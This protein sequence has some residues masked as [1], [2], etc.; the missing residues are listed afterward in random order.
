MIKIDRMNENDLDIFR[1]KKVIVD[2]TN[3]D[4]F[5]QIAK[6]FKIF[7]VDIAAYYVQN[8]ISLMHHIIVKSFGGFPKIIQK[9]ELAFYLKNT[10]NIIYLGEN[11]DI[12]ETLGRNLNLDSYDLVLSEFSVGQII[13]SFQYVLL[14]HSFANAIEI[15]MKYFYWDLMFDKEKSPVWNEFVNKNLEE[16]VVICSPQKTADVS[17][18]TTFNKI[19][20]IN[21]NGTPTIN[22]TNLWHKQQLIHRSKSRNNFKKMKIIIGIREPISQ[23]LSS[24]YQNISEGC[25]LYGKMFVELQKTSEKNKWNTIINKYRELLIND[26]DNAQALWDVWTNIYMLCNQEDNK[27]HSSYI[28]LF[29]RTFNANVVD[30]FAAP[31]NKEEGFGVISDGNYEVFVYQLEKLN[32]IV[33]E[34]S[35]WIGVP[36]TK[37]EKTNVGEN[38]WV[39]SSYKNALKEIQIT[40]NYFDRC[41]DEPY[42]KHFYSESD[43]EKFKDRWRP[44]IR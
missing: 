43:I 44:H 16:P 18:V 20:E 33:P 36:F 29:M 41:F 35:R 6:I 3:V 25:N 13:A 1:D 38:K 19:N 8:S 2:I 34:L 37:L 11:K 21:I 40:Q 26:A 7:N 17:L 23:N 24:L 39:G 27:T 32:S 31:F 12:K 28:Q 5:L 22:Y 9:E 14:A 42:V 10:E 30:L 15:K 4:G